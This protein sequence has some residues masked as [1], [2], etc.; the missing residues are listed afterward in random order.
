MNIFESRLFSMTREMGCVAVRPCS[1]VSQNCM[2]DMKISCV[3]TDNQFVKKRSI[4][5]LFSYMKH[6]LFYLYTSHDSPSDF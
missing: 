2:D 3:I 4:S 6:E 1:I 5:I